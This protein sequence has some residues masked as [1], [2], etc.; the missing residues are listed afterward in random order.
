MTSTS[1]TDPVP[2][3]DLASAHAEVADEVAAGFADVLAHTAFIGGAAGGRVRARVRR[4]SSG[5]RPLRRRRQRHRRARAGAARARRRPGDE[6]HPAGEH[7]HRHRRGGRA[8]RRHAGAR[9]LSTTDTA[10]IDVDATARRGHRSAPA[11]SPVHLYGQLAPVGAARAACPHGRRDR[12]GRR[13]VPGRDAATGRPPARSA[14]LAATSFY[15]G[16]NLGAYGD[17]GAVLTDDDD[18]R[19]APS[20]CSATTAARASTS[21]TCSASTAGSTR[22]RPSCCR[23]SCA[24]STRGTTPA[25][26]PPPATTSCSA[27]VDGGRC[28]SSLAG[29]EHV[30]HLYVVRVARARR[31]CCAE[32]QRRPASA[33]ASTT[34]RRSTCTGAFA[35]LGPRAGDFPVAEQRPSEILSLPLFP[36]ITAAQQ[37][38]V[39]DV[40]TSGGR[41]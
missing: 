17:A 4:R 39:V 35:D 38:R 23:P 22:C 10:L 13:A 28:P 33:P 7:V 26:P 37:E 1:A 34:R 18:A 15:P 8:R 5:V 12:R 27:D 24:G 2:L 11:P 25:A 36:Q 14:T 3:V 30:W 20:G 9:R 21:T 29:N 41:R 31:A 19:R 40:L 16:K 6:V 32:L